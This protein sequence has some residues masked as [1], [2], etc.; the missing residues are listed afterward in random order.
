MYFGTGEGFGNFDAING[1]GVWK[2]TDGGT[3]WAQ[4]SSTTNISYVNDL[5]FDD[6]GY[7]YAAT[8]STVASLRGII[9]SIDNGTSWTQVVIDPIPTAIP[10]GAD[11]ERSI[12]G[13]MYATLGI[14]TT[15]H[16]FRSAANGVNTGVSGSWT[17]I[18][19]ASIITNKDGRVEL[20]VCPNNS[21]RLYAMSQDSITPA[22]AGGGIGNLFR[23]DN[24]GASWT[25][26]TSPNWCDINTTTT[27]FSRGQAWY[28]LILGVNPNDD[29]T[30]LAG[31]VVVMKSANSGSSWTQATRWIA[32]SCSSAPII[33]ADIHEIQFLNSSEIIIC[34]DGGIYYSSDGGASFVNKNNGYNVTQYYGVAVAASSGS[35]TMLAGAQDN[36]SHLFN[37]LGINSVSSVTG[38]DGGFC[39]IDKT[40][41]TVWITSNPG[42]YFNI[43]RSSGSTFIGTAGNGSGRFVSV[44][45]YADTIDVLYSGDGDG[46]YRRVFNVES[47]SASQTTVNLSTEMGANRQVSCVKVDPNDE[48]TIWLGCSVSENASA[49]VTPRLLKVIRANGPTSG[50]PS[51]QPAA[52][53][54]TGP[55]LSAGA[56]ISSIDI[57]KGNS[58]HMV[59]T[60]SNYGVASI[61][62]STDG[63]V[64]WSSLDN[65]GVNL[66][67]MP[68]RWAIFIPSG[69]S[70]RTTST[71]SIGGIMLATELGVWTT[72]SSNGIS[73]VWAANNIGL[74]NVRVDQLVLRNSD[75]LVAAATHGRGIF[76][77]L[78][79][80]GPL[81]VSLLNF[82]G[83]L[84]Q[85]NILL[86][87]N[88]SYEFNSSHFEL[89]K[90]YDGA[91]FQKI[92]KITAAGNSNSLQQYSYLDQ[93]TL[94]E[95]NYYRLKMVDIDGKFIYAQTIVV[96]N[97]NTL[98]NVRVIGNPFKTFTKVQL[99]KTPQQRVQFDLIS[100]SGVKMYHGEFERLTELTLD[101][102]K[103]NLSRGA[104]LLRA[105]VDGQL[106]SH[107][108]IKE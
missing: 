25:T 94:S 83:R 92:A 7:I 107:K 68:I 19:P 55:S 51:S 1:L 43:Y 13:D 50:P 18:T 63:G 59:L 46:L 26:L 79:L 61:W 35:N 52:T 2:S 80:T 96:R 24:S 100:L 71:A 10:R 73:T 49:N 34:N 20:A 101:F 30:V 64:N 67:D 44:A 70:A 72:S 29:A 15:G 53:I 41:S 21:S 57:E 39:F 9:R 42:G 85:N 88:T 77:T 90:S 47:G 98:Q 6:N 74:A 62:E 78:L 16:I 14:F 103:I 106:F 102:S 105:N 3:T 23:S 95:F 93:G 22:G 27:D 31:G 4:L 48:T 99:A 45:D 54:F 104:Y 84:Y 28:D 58:N 11:L 17:D 66:P 81:P 86:E 38:G 37:S 32:G 87:W 60:V 33:H 69:Y 75:K 97:P 12:N 89:E 5:E 56:Y 65:N 76:T 36:G 108:L 91:N 8:R 82:N 40:N